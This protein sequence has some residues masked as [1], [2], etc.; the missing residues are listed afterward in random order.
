[1]TSRLIR[2]FSIGFLALLLAGCG[3]NISG[4]S[5]SDGMGIGDGSADSSMGMEPAKIGMAPAF[6][7]GAVTTQSVIRTADLTIETSGVSQTF[8][9][10]KTLVVKLGGRI[11]SSSVFDQGQEFG[12]N[13]YLTVRIAETKLDSLIEQVSQL[14]K[15]TALNVYTSDVT[16]QTIDLK[17][18][19]EALSASRDRLLELLEQATTTAD[20]I[21]AEQALATRQSELD[22][23]QS[24]LEYLESQISE[25]TLTIQIV[26]DASSVTNGLRG[27]QETLLVAA[28][29][30]LKAFENI[31]IFVGTAIPWLL[32]AGLLYAVIKGS[33]RL[34]KKRKTKK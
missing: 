11:E 19:V 6:E 33:K 26:D 5:T 29:N 23:Y 28:Q 2:N 30:F 14:G 3:V 9:E 27:I 8:T 7:S 24:Q 12:P 31:V 20:L 25:S 10:T 32:V 34:V 17:A 13:A 4:D 18:K 15:Q 1:M 21:A 16:L 22:S